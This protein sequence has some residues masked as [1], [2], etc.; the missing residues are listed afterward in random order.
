M[1]LKHY[2]CMPLCSALALFAFTGCSDDDIAPGG[3]KIPEGNGIVFGASAGY[4]KPSTRVEYGDY[5]YKGGYEGQFEYRISQDLNWVKGDRVSIFSPTSPNTTKQE[6]EIDN[7]QQTDASKA[8]LAVI[9]GNDGLQWSADDTQ[10]F[11]AVYPSRE[12]MS[13]TTVKD[14]FVSFDNGVLTGYVP[15]N[16][17]HEITYAEGTG[18]WTAK[19]N[20]DYLYMAAVQKGWSTSNDGISLD[21]VP[22]TTTLEVTLVGPTTTPIA[23]FNIEAADANGDPVPVVGQFRCDLK[24]AG[25]TIA[26]N[27]ETAPDC[28][29]LQQGTT[30]S[31]ATVSC[32]WNDNGT[33]K[34]LTLKAGEEITFNVFLL[35]NE[36]L[37]KVTIRVAGFNTSSRSL[38]FADRNGTTIKLNPHTKTCVK[39]P[40]PVINA[41][42]TNEWITGLEDN[43][44]VSQL[45]IPGTANSFSYEY[46]GGTNTHIYQT[47]TAT[48]EKQWNAGIRC[49]ELVCPENGGDVA[50]SRLQCNRTNLSNNITFATAVDEIWSLV[51]AH[52]GEFAIIIPSYDSDT[53]HPDSHDGVQNFANG[54]NSFYDSHHD[55]TYQTYTSTLTVGEARGSLIFIARITSEEDAEEADNNYTLPRP[56]KGT[57]VDQWG[58]LKD[59][60]ARRGYTIDGSVVNNWG[61]SPTDDSSMER[62]MFYRNDNVPTRFP[63]RVDANANF[64]HGATREDGTPGYAYIQDWMRVVPGTNEI[65]GLQG[66]GSYL[67]HF[68]DGGWFSSDTYYRV[69]WNE[70]LKEKKNDIW[71]TFLRSIQQN[72]LEN[73]DAFYINSLDGYFVDQNIDESFTPYVQTGSWGVGLS[74]GGTGGNIGAWAT[75]INNWFYGQILDYGEDNIYGPMNIIILDRVYDD[76][77]SSYLPSVIIN[78]NYRFPLRTAGGGTTGDSQSNADSSYASGGSVWH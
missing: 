36:Q 78:N 43:V 8:Y 32:Y 17:Q 12:S 4:S 5:E 52:P 38:T 73:P 2:L 66:A 13:N 54:L 35:P 7:V 30:N 29:S 39:I 23:S 77:P 40:A 74:K 26:G 27:F 15:I 28:V 62:Y 42:G 16:Q 9:D 57:F 61:L 11:Y 76:D 75:H 46:D 59:N 1:N 58:S 47:Q 72:S 34:P 56:H 48:I 24:K 25:T 33:R 19:P 55:Y 51:K 53:G 70:S 22:L 68:E 3:G 50:N 21:F 31:Y 6:Y 45:S 63:E 67:L 44:L 60:W 41:G 71:N 65:S 18:T 20:M 69:W 49:F 64:Y 10:D 14:N 37:D